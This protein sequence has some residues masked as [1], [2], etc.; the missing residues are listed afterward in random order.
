MNILLIV[1]ELRY[2][3]GVTNHIIHLSRGLASSGKVKLWIIT[4]GGNGIDRFKDINV[5]IISDKR[6]FHKGRGL[7]SYLSA[8]TFLTKFIRKNKI[9]VVHSHNHYAANISSRA[10]K[11][12]KANTIQT[13][14]GLLQ[15]KGRLKHFNADHYIAINEHISEYLLRNKIAAETSIS[16]IR[17]GVPVDPRP[18]KKQNGKL[19]VIAA[20]RFKYGKGLDIFI[21]A[22]ASLDKTE[23]DKAEFY[24]AGEGELENSLKELNSST[25]AGI[26]FLGSVKDIYSFLKDTHILVHPSRSKS[27]GFPAIITEA[28][29]CNNLVISSDFTGSHSVI[30]NDE[31]LFFK[32][33]DPNELSKKL[34]EAILNYSQYENTSLKFY[35]KV[36]DWFDLDTMISKHIEL[37]DKLMSNA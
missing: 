20:S 3:C 18:A 22:V 10:A 27:E 32:V 16:L 1:N 8:I 14:H 15:S 6:F 12:S 35:N 23:K 5:N 37:Y 29:A 31:G 17:C 9:D 30:A 4:G 36:K 2:T 26:K 34:T 21:N 28:G 13:N 25:S 11:I 24:I 33:D 19:K 7:G